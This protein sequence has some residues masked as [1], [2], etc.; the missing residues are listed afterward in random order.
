MNHWQI[1]RIVLALCGIFAAGILTGR[2]TAPVP[3][4]VAA[5]TASPQGKPGGISIDLDEGR[6]L[7][8]AQVARFYHRVLNFTPA[9][10]GVIIPI[11]RSA[12][13][14][15]QKT[16]PGS[17]ERQE[18][19]RRLN[20]EVRTKLNPDQLATFDKVVAESEARWTAKH[21]GK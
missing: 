21:G 4:P 5:P 13:I 12:M 3:A 20:A 7:D 14:G 19:L 11:I 15:L 10:K 6:T 8:S 16:K 1:I 9:Q 2:F 17:P 18:A